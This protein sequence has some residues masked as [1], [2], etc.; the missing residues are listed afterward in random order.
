MIFR[1]DSEGRHQ[2]FINA[3]Q[4]SARRAGVAYFAFAYDL[5]SANHPAHG[6]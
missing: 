5:H 2:H 1:S 6:I 4:I 3:M